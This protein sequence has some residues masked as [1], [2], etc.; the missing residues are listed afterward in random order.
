MR[1]LKLNLDGLSVDTFVAGKAPAIEGTVRGHESDDEG[2][3][4]IATG[5]VTCD[6][7]C[8]TCPTGI[9]NACCV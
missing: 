5:Y 8:W 7:T 3:Q 6:S 2:G 9:A 4:P 1:P